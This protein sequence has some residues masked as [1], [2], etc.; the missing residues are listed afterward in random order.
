VRTLNLL[1]F[2]GVVFLAGTWGIRWGV[3]PWSFPSLGPTLTG[4]WDGP[5][6]ANL[7]AQYRI[8]LDLTYRDAP[9][10]SLM[11]STL[12]GQARICNRHGDVYEYTVGGGASRSGDTVEIGLSFVDP[13][14]SALGNTLR[15]GWDG[16][17]L[18]LQPLTNPFMPDGTFLLHRTV[19]TDDPDDSFG[20]ASLHKSDA[21]SF[22]IACGRLTG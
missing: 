2:V 13:V 18:T 16:Q 7:G 11:K 8:Y 12:M 19:S 9:G 6:K 14:R 5:L 22:L 17:T 15:G 3:A 21:A 1:A 4:T 20:P 10:R